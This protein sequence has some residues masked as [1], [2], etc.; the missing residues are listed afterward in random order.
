LRALPTP[1]LLISLPKIYRDP[2]A[3]Q[4]EGWNSALSCVLIARTFSSLD[5]SD[6]QI[7]MDGI[8]ASWTF[9]IHDALCFAMPVKSIGPN[10][11]PWWDP[12]LQA[13]FDQRGSAY[14]ALA[15]YCNNFEQGQVPNLSADPIWQDLWANYAELRRKAHDVVQSNRSRMGALIVSIAINF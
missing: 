8:Y 14:A 9:I 11:K 2:V 5:L 6:Q 1:Y 15:S 4:L 3:P 7:L 13:L 10:S 12:C